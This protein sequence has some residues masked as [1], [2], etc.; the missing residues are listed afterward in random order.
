MKRS[1]LFLLGL[2]LFTLPPCATASQ[3]VVTDVLGRTH[4]FGAPV[5]RLIC[6]GAGCL[7]LAVL[8]QAQDL[9]VAVDDME[10]RKGPFDARPYALANPGLSQLP[11]FGQFRGRDNPEKILG[12]SPQP[13]VIFKT[14]PTAGHDPVKLET[15]TGIPVVSLYFGDLAAHRKDFFNALTLMGQVLNKEE[16][17]NE[18]IAFFTREIRELDQRTRDIP[19][20]DRPTCFVGGIAFKGPHGFAST[21][22]WYPPFQFVH[23]RNIACPGPDKALL[24]H[25]IFSKES[26]LN[27]DPQILFLDLSTLQM[28]KG[29]GGLHEL[30]TDPVFMGLSAAQAGRIYGVLPYNWYSQ[31][32]SSI[33]A[34]AWFIGKVLYPDRFADVDPR[35]KADEVYEFLVGRPLFD[36]MDKSFGNMAFRAVDL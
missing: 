35:A 23:A 22:P 36:R 29:Q 13:Q 7:R 33:I 12:L 8:L 27:T 4:T 32:P 6:S 34:D 15:K 10:T 9:V 28:G 26:L 31:N 11:L 16:R 17:A 21:E 1:A 30:K 5:T 25:S 14:Y 19:E 3:T 24:R 20:E 2:L 18:V